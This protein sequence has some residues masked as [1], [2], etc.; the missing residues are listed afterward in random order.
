[1]DQSFL[2]FLRAFI[3]ILVRTC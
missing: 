3:N 2:I 1:M